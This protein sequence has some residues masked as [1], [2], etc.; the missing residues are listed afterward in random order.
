MIYKLGKKTNNDLQIR[1]KKQ[2][3]IYK[4]EKKTNND[5]KIKKKNKQ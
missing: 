2:T 3:M 1:Y 5:Q 4:L